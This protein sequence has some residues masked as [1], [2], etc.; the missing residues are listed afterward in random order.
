MLLSMTDLLDLPTAPWALAALD[1]VVTREHRPVANHSIR[2]YLFA[3]LLAEHE[4]MSAEVDSRLL[5]AATVLHDIGL[6]P[7]TTSRARFEVDGADHAAE[8]LRAN[9]FGEPEI[10][11]VWEAIALH[12]SPGIA[13][14]RGPIAMLTRAGVGMDFGQGAEIVDDEQAK[15]IHQAYPR[16]SMAVSVVEAIVAQCEK[17]PEKG[18]RYSI[19]GELTRERRTP[20]HLTQIER[21][22][23]TSRWGD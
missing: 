5:F 1:L 8:F 18:P 12:T 13:E 9:G 14:R 20:P 23:A 7:D 15:R 16:L 19:A 3:R 6:R 21:A 2:S 11:V 22:A 4:G 17:M 10:D